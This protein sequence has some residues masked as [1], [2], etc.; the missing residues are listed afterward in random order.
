[1]IGQQPLP[2]GV[3]RLNDRKSVIGT[4]LVEQP[5]ATMQHQGREALEYSITSFH[6]ETKRLPSKYG[7]LRVRA[8]RHS[9]SCRHGETCAMSAAA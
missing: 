4:V 5:D 8:Y 2:L 7:M 9:V 6:A 3:T 1:M